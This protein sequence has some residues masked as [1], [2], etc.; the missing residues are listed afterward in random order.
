MLINFSLSTE[1]TEHQNIQRS[2]LA[3]GLDRLALQQLLL[4]IV[5]FQL[6]RKSVYI[7]SKDEAYKMLLFVLFSMSNPQN[8]SN[9]T[10]RHIC[11]TFQYLTNTHPESHKLQV[12]AQQIFVC[13]SV[14][15]LEINY[16]SCA[17]FKHRVLF[18]KSLANQIGRNLNSID[19]GQQNVN[20]ST[21]IICLFNIMS[22]LCI[23]YT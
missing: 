16:W 22:R 8:W 14:N 11:V 5:V 9:Q 10:K 12:P 2:M 23:Q 19:I 7:Y 4:K 13:F 6:P 20:Q 18:R 21:C 17:P 15:V 1:T 3:P